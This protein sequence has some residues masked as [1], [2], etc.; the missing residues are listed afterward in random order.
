[1]STIAKLIDHLVS[2]TIRTNPQIQHAMELTGAVVMEAKRA[3]VWNAL[4]DAAVLQACIPGCEEVINESDTVRRARVMIKLGPVRARFNGTLTLSEVV[5]PERCLMSFE[6]SGGAAGMASGRS[7]VELIEEGGQTRVTYTVHASV[8]GKLGQIG[9][10]LL[11]ASA[12]QLAD[13]FFAALRQHLAPLAELA[14]ASNEVL[15][16]VGPTPPLSE[17]S[18]A[19]FA[20]SASPASPADSQAPA[21]PSIAVPVEPPRPIR[22]M[23]SEVS[24]MAAEFPRLFWFAMGVFSTGFGVWLGSRL[25]AG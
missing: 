22:I 12:R 25:F 17:P 7:Q 20:S 18:S 8:G 2:M 16:P 19:S 24:P 6:G 13:Q 5:A 23:P 10:R 21:G 9:G 1:M 14:N 15:R 11:D 4:N 3:E